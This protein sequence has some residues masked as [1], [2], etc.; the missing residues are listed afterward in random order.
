MK[1]I[2][3]IDTVSWMFATKKNVFVGRDSN[4]KKQQ[5]F[6]HSSNQ[7]LK[8]ENGKK[9]LLLKEPLWN[10][11][12]YKNGFVFSS[13]EG[14]VINHYSN[15][16]VD[17]EF[18]EPGRG[19]Y[20]FNPMEKRS[21]VDVFNFQ[22]ISNLKQTNFLKDKKGSEIQTTKTYKYVC[23]DHLVYWKVKEG[24]IEVNKIEAGKPVLKWKRNDFEKFGR[25]IFIGKDGNVFKESENSLSPDFFPY[26][27]NLSLFVVLRGGQIISFDLETGKE[28]WFWN[29]GTEIYSKSCCSKKSIFRSSGYRL[30]KIDIESGK[31]I[32]NIEIAVRGQGM[33]FHASGPV[34][35]FGNIVTVMDAHNGK[36]KVYTESLEFVGEFTEGSGGIINDNSS[37]IY[38][39]GYLYIKRMDNCC[40]IY[41]LGL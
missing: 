33:K 13:F 21:T 11:L 7:L 8:I 34:Q 40:Y 6:I 10:F 16:N 28:N 22:I 4:A 39:D 17:K 27:D 5:Q 15:G 9:E 14:D 19:K 25:F 38:H 29:E 3:K 36:V 35:S 20:F 23:K 26:S 2:S 30:K 31:T 18:M 1:S 41:K 12:P 24:Y 37:V 32:K